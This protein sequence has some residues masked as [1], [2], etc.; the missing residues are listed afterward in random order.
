METAQRTI[1]IMIAAFG[2]AMSGAYAG[3][4]S[5][6]TR[7]VSAWRVPATVNQTAVLARKGADDPRP[8]PGC[9][10]HG[11]DICVASDRPTA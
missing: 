6:D 4:S 2:F 11:T 7:A 3:T 9:D 8:A 5:N 1:S 10:D